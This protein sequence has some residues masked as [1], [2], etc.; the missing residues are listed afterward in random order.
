MNAK[1]R[2]IGFVLTIGRVA[3]LRLAP[4]TA[5]RT[6]ATAIAGMF[7]IIIAMR[8]RTVV[9]AIMRRPSFRSAANLLIFGSVE[10]RRWIMFGLGYLS[11][12]AAA[13]ASRSQHATPERWRLLSEPQA[14]S[15]AQLYFP[16]WAFPDDAR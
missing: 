15:G 2:I 1:Q 8:F 3:W 11:A 6:A 16:F 5:M 9:A 4:D 10:A 7:A 13:F 12:I 14:E